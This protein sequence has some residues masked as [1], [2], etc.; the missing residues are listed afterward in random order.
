M[1]FGDF[2]IGQAYKHRSDIH[3]RFGGQRQGGISTPVRHPAVFAFSGDSG[4][5]HGYVDGW[6]ADG[7]YRYFGEGQQGPMAWKGGNSASS[8]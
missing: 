1:A 6:T 5:R 7:V 3:D 2:Q 8:R 4:V